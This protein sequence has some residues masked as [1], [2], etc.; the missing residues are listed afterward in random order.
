MTL[1]SARDADAP[2][3][4][5]LQE[6]PASGLAR[7]IDLV[8]GTWSAA[9]AVDPG[10]PYFFDHPLDHLPG[11]ALVSGLL[12]LLR[13]TGAGLPERA[14]SRMALTLALPSFCELDA[15]VH[16]E[17]T[18]LP[19]D[20]S[21][22]PGARKVVLR[23]RQFDRAVCEGEAVF[24]PAAPVP[25]GTA[26]GPDHPDQ[27]DGTLVH[28]HR[29]ENVLVSG[30][31][32]DGSTRTV[33][34]RRP[35]DGHPLAAGPGEPARAEV[36]IDAARQFGTMICHVEHSLADDARLVLLS[37]EADLPGGVLADL[38]LR[39]TWR[40]PVRGRSRMEIDVVA[41]DPAGEACGGVGLDYYA[42]SPAVYRRLRG[43]GGPA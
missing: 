14:G 3:A 4:T 43:A 28:R 42:A 38:Y 19:A 21:G 10:D 24:A 36:V 25:E 34:V 20:A 40:P 5:L 27:R 31:I 1:L 13:A 30:M 15:P 32:P 16:L 8:T 37:I 9:L 17:A 2:Q 11:M 39:W 18:R 23:A 6:R 12:D 22:L 7:D 41:G 26:T 35:A 33:R 29:A